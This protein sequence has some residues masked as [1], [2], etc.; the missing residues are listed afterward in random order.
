MI[1]VNNYLCKEKII[2]IVKCE[3]CGNEFNKKPSNIKKTR[4]NFCNMKCCYKQ[5][6]I[7]IYNRDFFEEI[8]SEERAYWLGFIL[9][10]GSIN[11][12]SNRI[13]ITLARKDRE[14]LIKFCNIFKKTLEEF[15]HIG[16]SHNGKIKTKVFYTSRCVVC[17]RKLW[18][19]LNNKGIEP[20]KTLKD[21]IEIFN[22]IPLNLLNHFIRGYFDGDGCICK[23]SK[24]DKYDIYSFHIVGTKQI[25]NLVSDILYQNCKINKMKVI[26]D[27]SI[28]RIYCGGNLQL[29]AIRNWLYKNA[30]IY[31]ERKKS[32][33]DKIKNNRKKLTSTYNG[34]SFILKEKKWQSTININKKN[35]FLGYFDVEK[36]AAKAYNLAII[37][38]NLPKYK[39]NIL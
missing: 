28:Y 11:S 35:I 32:I 12:I 2:M 5:K 9:A 36:E 4:H 22:H 3:N 8:N 14:H 34:V 19:D 27:K 21:N 26:P 39:L 37:D 29:I 7:D 24:N 15:E 30:H 13:H 10:D 16:V 17:S 20:N 6:D 38:N 1:K 33:F 25:L 18:N 23:R 31:L